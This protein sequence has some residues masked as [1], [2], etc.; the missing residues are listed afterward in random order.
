MKRKGP[1]SILRSM[2]PEAVEKFVRKTDGLDMKCFLLMH[3]V[4]D[5]RRRRPKEVGE[6]LGGIAPNKAANCS[7][8]PRKMLEAFDLVFSK[9]KKMSKRAK[10]RG[11]AN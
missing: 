6:A 10:E 1:L 2:P 8:R 11:G 3:G 7:R 5:G 9:I 4:L